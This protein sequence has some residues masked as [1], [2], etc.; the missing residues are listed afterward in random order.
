MRNLLLTLFACLFALCTQAAT[1]TEGFEDVTI[2]D[3]D[4]NPLSSSW[5]AGYGL[6]NGWKV[7]GGTIYS[8]AGTGNYGLW[9]KGH[10]GS[11]SLEASYSSTN[12]AFV[13]IPTKVSGELKFWARKTSTSSRTKGTLNI[14]EVTEAEGSYA[15]G[16][17]IATYDLTT[18][19]T[20]YTVDLGTE[21]KFIAINMV[22]A[23]IDDVTY[24]TFE[25]AS[26]PQL[27]VT[28]DG[29]KAK[30]G[31]TH[32]F[33]LV[34]SDS[35]TT[36][37][38]ANTGVGTLNATL[39]ATKGY[40]LSA[41]AVSVEAGKDTA[42]TVTQVADTTGF[43]HGTVTI[44]AA[45]VDTLTLNLQGIVRDINKIYI[46]FD[47]I[48]EG[49]TLNDNSYATI[50]DGALKANYWYAAE[51]TSPRIAV[52]EGEQLYFRYK[53]ATSSSYQTPTIN[54][55]YSTDAASWTQVGDNYATDA[56]NEAWHSALI[57]GIPS[58]AQ[59]IRFSVKYVYLD[60][61]YGFSLPQE[62]I[63]DAEVSDIDFGMTTKDSTIT[64]VVRNQGAKA[65]EGLKAMVG[66]SAFTVSVPETIAAKAE[67]KLS[68]TMSANV[69]GL[70]NDTVL[71]TAEGQDTVRFAVEGYV[72]DNEAMLVEFDSDSLPRGWEN[73]GWTISGVKAQAGYGG[74]SPRTLTTPQLVV[75]D[76]DVLAFRASKEYASG[77]LRLYSS[78][79][80]GANWTL[81]R[82]FEPEMKADTMRT[83]VV[84]GLAAGKTTLRFDGSYANIET[85]NGL[86]VD[87][88]A[89]KMV[90]TY[91]DKALNDRD[92]INFGI[93]KE[94]LVRSLSIRN[95]G[96]GTLNVKISIADSTQFAVSDSVLS[97][98]QDETKAL[99]V[100]LPVGEPF[101][102]K[103]TALT[104]QP[105]NE[106]LKAITI[107][108]NGET[109]D[110]TLWSE[111]F[112]NG[113]SELWT[114]H[115]W[116][117][118]KPY[119]GNGTMM[120]YAT[121]SDTTYI[122]TPRLKA[123]K[124]DKLIYQ[125]LL[126]W[127]DE[128]MKVE[129]STD[130]QKTWT[131]DSVYKFTNNYTLADLEFTAPED[132]FYFIR[133]SGGYSYIDNF[134]GFRYADKAHDIEISSVAMPEKVYQYVET[135]AS[136]TLRELNDRNETV[137]ATLLVNGAEVQTLDSIALPAGSEKEFSFTYRSEGNADS[138]ALQIRFD[139]DGDTLATATDTVEYIVAPIISEAG[140]FSLTASTYP[141]IVL[142]LS[143]EK[144]WNTIALPFALD[145]LALL[146]N[147][148]A[149]NVTGID[150]NQLKITAVTELEAGYPYLLN[151]D[152]ASAI[153]TVLYNVQ[154]TAPTALSR[155]AGSNTF[156]ATYD[157]I[158]ATDNMLILDA[159]KGQFVRPEAGVSISGLHGYITCQD[160]T[161]EKLYLLSDDGKVATGITTIVNEKKADGKTYDLSGR[162]VNESSAAKGVYIRNGKK[163]IRK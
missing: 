24:S 102:K 35:S 104:I 155:I 12:N 64:F 77:F 109:R 136:A 72:I 27:T 38:I 151:A 60:D 71:L 44:A 135:K 114:N 156:Y 129:F 19:W 96:T 5:S 143:T 28:M 1:T 154:I 39:T 133:F 158:A 85:I 48:P 90:L 66:D 51:L 147:A 21:G 54:V 31:Y 10:T 2:V 101:G 162:R 115:G 116:T 83:L 61:I 100:T 20:E 82:D 103:A 153:D 45:D 159:A 99:N 121:A 47:S 68:V 138:I 163:F 74:Q 123:K 56:T 105:T 84:S 144:G 40:T 63:M 89:P 49:W 30:S 137:S 160:A 8:S 55:S 148:K 92:S 9:T 108:L 75:A 86:H 113:I 110:S 93:T 94:S 65:L 152:M 146:N 70:H 13:V 42:I 127:T 58:T 17:T 130:E 141:A 26:T 43:K 128:D 11:K 91:N 59:Y 25:A 157:S 81:V 50:E 149:Y 3:A 125:A 120:G 53:R 140:K 14:W 37:T 33:G 15:K 7:V 145:S 134:Y 111:D 98:G 52:S 95:T 97:V 79:D 80:Q 73:E 41:P 67:G 126:P 22:R 124:G 87:D 78:T 34:E 76:G 118:E 57:D 62:A 117:T 119:Y 46:N 106:G 161:T 112:E 4:G 88:N 142:R 23:G 107:N 18:T 6:S 29:A 69:K 32:D 131:V 132:G 122:I 16:S 150:G 139:Y 36:F